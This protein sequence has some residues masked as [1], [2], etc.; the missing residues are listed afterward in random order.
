[1]IKSIGDNYRNYY[2]II[3]KPTKKKLVLK[4]GL[5]NATFEHLTMLSSERIFCCN[6]EN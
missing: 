4:Y 1:M 5:S 6:M 3:V 2:L